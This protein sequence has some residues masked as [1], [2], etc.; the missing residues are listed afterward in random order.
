[1]GQLFFYNR[2]ENMNKIIFL[3]FFLIVFAALAESFCCG[4]PSGTQART[5]TCAASGSCNIFCCNCAGSCQ[6]ERVCKKKKNRSRSWTPGKRKRSTDERQENTSVAGI[7][8]V[9]AADVDGN[10]MLDYEEASQYLHHRNKRN[11]NMENLDWFSSLDTN[12]DGFLSAL[13]ID[14]QE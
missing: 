10:S 7:D 6:R 13:E 4:C 8:I 14:P 1:M 5:G 3:G 2:L 9:I 12:S 11:V